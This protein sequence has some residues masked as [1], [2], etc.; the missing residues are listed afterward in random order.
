[1]MKFIRPI[2]L[3]GVFLLVASGLR[4]TGHPFLAA[5]PLL[6]PSDPASGARITMQIVT[7]TALL[8]VGIYVILSKR[9][10][11]A[12]KHWAYATLG[13][14]LGFWLPK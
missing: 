8:G 5:S 7:S 14:I 9:Y 2:F 3:V 10:A 13:T 11:P 12:D 6:I 1:M 4:Q